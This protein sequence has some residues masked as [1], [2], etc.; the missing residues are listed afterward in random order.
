MQDLLPI[1][2]WHTLVIK[3]LTSFLILDSGQLS[4]SHPFCFFLPHVRASLCGSLHLSSLGAHKEVHRTPAHLLTEHTKATHPFLLSSHFQTTLGDCPDPQ[5]P[6]CVNNKSLHTL[7]GF[8]WHHFIQTDFGEGVSIP[9][10]MGQPQ[11]GT[12]WQH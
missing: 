1:G 2:L 9:P 8:M 10:F 5:K 7:L 12:K 6:Q 11:A 3:T 4:G